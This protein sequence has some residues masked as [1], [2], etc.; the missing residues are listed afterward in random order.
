MA[1]SDSEGILLPALMDRFGGDSN[2]GESAYLDGMDVRQLKEAVARDLEWLLNTRVW[3]PPEARDFEALEESRASNL[4]Y[5]IPDL[6]VY[7][8]TSA[9]DATVIARAVEKAVRAF[10]PRL[11]P[12]SVKCHVV[13]NEDPNEL[14]LR[15]RIEAVLYV[16]PISERVAFDSAADVDGGGIRIESF[17]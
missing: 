13:P 3:A 10:E 9:S 16:E 5:G 15:V 14:S 4:N 2:R 1:A 7:S 17:E 11:L 6:S 12:R 8:W